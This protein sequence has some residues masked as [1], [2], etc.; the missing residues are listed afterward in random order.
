MNPASVQ[1]VLTTPVI[2]DTLGENYEF[3]T[4]IYSR[5]NEAIIK[6]DYVLKSCDLHI[7]FL[8]NGDSTDAINKLNELYNNTIEKL[9]NAYEEAL[10]EELCE[11]DEEYIDSLYEERKEKIEF[12]HAR[13]ISYIICQEAML[14]DFGT[15]YMVVLFIG[16][17]IYG[18]TLRKK[19]F[20]ISE[21]LM[22]M[23]AYIMLGITMIVH[24][25]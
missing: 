24:L 13:N 1:K 25:F 11:A 15:I 16:I 18:F 19:E 7:R 9:R 14:V 3:A 5:G 22:V 21:I 8:D 23:S 10:C 17:T 4:E 20:A 2:V 12:E 6:L